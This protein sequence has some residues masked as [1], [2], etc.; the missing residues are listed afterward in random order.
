MKNMMRIKKVILCCTAVVFFSVSLVPLQTEARLTTGALRKES[1]K[2][3]PS[4]GQTEEQLKVE[5]EEELEAK[6]KELE[7]LKNDSP[8]YLITCQYCNGTQISSTVCKRCNGTGIMDMPGND[9]T[10]LS[11][12]FSCASCYGSGYEQCKM[13]MGGKMADPDYNVKCDAWNEKIENLEGEIEQLDRQLHPEKYSSKGNDGNNVGAVYINPDP[14]WNLETKKA[15]CVRCKGSG[16]VICSTCQGSGY[17]S[18]IGYA[19]DYTGNGGGQY[20][21]QT[22]CACDNGYRSCTLCGGTGKN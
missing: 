11:M 2:Q 12:V 9:V 8:K 1:L 19:P 15:D 7:N 22:K 4:A 10:S 17:I 20:M 14:D 16:S 21:K 18:S 13:C 3:K 6:Q 5:Q